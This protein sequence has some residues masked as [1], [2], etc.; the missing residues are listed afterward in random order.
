M[1]KHLRYQLT[2]LRA[3]IKG[4]A[5]QATPKP[6]LKIGKYL[7]PEGVKWE[8]YTSGRMKRWHKRVVM[9]KVKNIMKVKGNVFLLEPRVCHKSRMGMVVKEKV[10]KVTVIRL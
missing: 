3:V 8:K 5:N 7:F 2:L 4:F 1:Q 6:V 10:D 9:K